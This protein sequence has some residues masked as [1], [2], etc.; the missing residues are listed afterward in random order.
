M[1]HALAVDVFGGVTFDTLT[2]H[3]VIFVIQSFRLFWLLIIIDM[4]L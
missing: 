4:A 2:I 3:S 1:H